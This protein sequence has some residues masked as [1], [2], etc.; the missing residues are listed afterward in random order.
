[1]LKILSGFLIG[2]GLY[3]VLL[4]S[5]KIPAIKSSKA[6][7]TLSQKQNEKT[8]TLDL[9][10]GGAA[11][12]LAKHLRMNEFKREELKENLQAIG[13]PLTP[14][15]FR[16]N[17]IVKA[18]FVSLFAIPFLF[19]FPLFVPVILI[20]AF[21]IYRQEDKK[22]TVGLQKRR[23][24][25]EASLPGFVS[26]VEKTLKHSRDVLA[27]VEGYIP[28]TENPFRQELKI[29]AADMR[30]GNEETAVT[31]LEAR[32]ASPQMSDVCRGLI[33]ILRGD[34]TS[35]YWAS[36]GL[37]FADENRQRLKREAQKA[38]KRVRWLSVALLGC[39]MLTYFVV[40]LSQIAD[41]LGVLFQ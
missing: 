13:N 35:V 40:I 16:A 41:S 5:F 39:F 26:T 14:E 9:W 34:E 23:E 28:H 32:V 17:A 3:L 11:K 7:R 2:I 12:F 22:L 37:K 24:Q 38:P 8:S 18:F 36:L 19:V 25:I 10:L 27:M 1:M 33:G 30:S 20:A 21:L 15:Q 29:T 31:R 4:D 6:V